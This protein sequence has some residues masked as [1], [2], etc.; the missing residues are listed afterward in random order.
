MVSSVVTIDMTTL[1]NN[2]CAVYG[3]WT[4]FPLLG[5]GVQGLV[6]YNTRYVIWLHQ[7]SLTSPGLERKT[8]HSQVEKCPS[9]CFLSQIRTHNGVQ[10]ACI[11][12]TQVPQR[13]LGAGFR[14]GPMDACG[15]GHKLWP[16][17]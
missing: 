2:P 13:P 5:K 10:P 15:T 4:Q 16:M 7:V 12:D 8:W 1:T 3:A 17:P 6:L 11:T 9:K 14:R